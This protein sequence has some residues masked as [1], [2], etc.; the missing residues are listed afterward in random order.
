VVSSSSHEKN[1]TKMKLL[2][3]PLALWIVFLLSISMDCAFSSSP[4]YHH[5]VGIYGIHEGNIEYVYQV[6]NGGKPKGIIF[7][8]HGCK[9][10]ARDWWP[11]SNSCP[12]CKALPVELS[13]V[14]EAISR[15]YAAIALSSENQEHHC[16]TEDDVPRFSS[17]MTYFYRHILKDTTFTKPLHMLGASSGGSFVGLFASSS[18][19]K[20]PIVSVCSEIMALRLYVQR[21]KIPVL[22]V[23]MERDE[24]T[25]YRVEKTI[26]KYSNTK[27]IK[28]TSQPLSKDYLY[29][30]GMGLVTQSDSE[31][32]FSILVK[33]SFLSHSNHLIDDPRRSNWRKVCALML[34]S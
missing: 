32:L 31:R 24:A 10:S 26:A 17:L 19:P 8:A 25:M 30:H 23:A 1:T 29:E 6:P 5:L 21:L 2:D 12:K 7:F 20:L 4:S 22:F 15:N 27:L 33:N 11:A 3:A 9:H 13:L 16:W 18:V 34:F 28:A 14:D